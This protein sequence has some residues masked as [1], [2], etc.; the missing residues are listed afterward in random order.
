M[1]LTRRE[2][3][4]IAATIGLTVMFGSMTGF[5]VAEVVNHNKETRTTMSAE[6]GFEVVDVQDAKLS[7]TNENF[8]AIIN[9]THKE[10]KEPIV[11]E[12]KLTATDFIVMNQPESNPWDY[13]SM[14]IIP[15]QDPTFVGTQKDYEE[16]LKTS[17]NI[18]LGKS[19]VYSPNNFP[20]QPTE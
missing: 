6:A 12:Y 9:C 20:L 3:D 15:N 11:I 2:K 10:T 13:L 17:A 7:Q 18:E 16:Y 4:M 14:Y 1:Y 19:G 5:A 8:K